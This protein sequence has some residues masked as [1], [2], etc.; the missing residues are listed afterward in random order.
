MPADS[1]RTP[2]SVDPSVGLE[3]EVLCWDSQSCTPCAAAPPSSAAGAQRQ[4]RRVPAPSPRA[5]AD[6]SGT[7]GWARASAVFGRTLS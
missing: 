1:H 5:G 3:A 7:L 2:W 6:G 4:P